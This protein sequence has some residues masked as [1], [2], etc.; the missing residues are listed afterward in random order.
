MGQAHRRQAGPLSW[1]Q[2][3]ELGQG[4][5]QRETGASP[6]AGRVKPAAVPS[7]GLIRYDSMCA[8]I[9]ECHRVDEAKDIRDKAKALEVYAKEALNREAED[10]ARE[11]RLRAERR[12]G[13]LYREAKKNGQVAKQGDNAGAHRGKARMSPSATSFATLSD[14]GISRDQSSQW[15]QLADV[16]QGLFDEEVRKPGATAENIINASNPSRP[17]P[18]IHVDQDAL[19]AYGRIADFDKIMTRP[20]AELFAL[21]QDFQREHIQAL[22]PK[23]IRWLRDMQ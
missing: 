15:Q 10:L 14:L 23:L 3:A 8:A 16:P 20:G 12:A 17:S 22:I 19:W 21:M 5:W 9:A 6:E 13:E 11:I 18:K 1:M 2:A 7:V 4:E